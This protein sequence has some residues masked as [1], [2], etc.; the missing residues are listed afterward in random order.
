MPRED[1][2]KRVSAFWTRSR[3]RYWEGDNYLVYEDYGERIVV[4]KLNYQAE[5]SAEIG[6]RYAEV[7]LKLAGS[8]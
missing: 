4:L 5:A 7:Y 6:Q 2:F 8:K 1:C 3:V